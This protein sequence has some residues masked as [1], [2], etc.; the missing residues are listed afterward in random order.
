[1]LLVIDIG[2]TNSVFA[3]FG[4]DDTVIAQ[5][6]LHSAAQRTADEYGLL[7][8]QACT[9]HHIHI[10]DIT[11]VIV[12]SVVPDAQYP[13]MQFCT[14][15]LN[16]I[17]PVIVGKDALAMNIAVDV[18]HPEEVGADR[19]VN[20]VEAWHKY[21]KGLLVL[22]FGTATTFDVVSS[23]GTY[24]GGVIAPGINLSL[25][26]LQQAAAKLPSVRVRQPKHIIGRNTVAAMESGIFYGYAELIC[27]IIKRIKEER[28]DIEL[29]IATGGLA[30]LYTKY[31]NEIDEISNE[32]TL[33][34]LKT[35]HR[36][37]T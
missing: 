27:G 8:S 7:C 10:G 1:M 2:N 34:G 17:S 22:D 18:D 6:R 21:K 36:I 5:W 4:D 13:I 37:N 3:V 28:S 29:V 35:L 20:A 19:L 26:A 14:Y 11:D 16:N 30:S 23:Q 9:H 32:L 12:A 25:Q 33:Y 15:Y 24:I 31:I